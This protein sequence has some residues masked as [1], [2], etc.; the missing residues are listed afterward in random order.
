MRKFFVTFAIPAA[1]I[2]EWMAKVDEA[3]RKEQSDKVMHE[4]QDWMGKHASS[5]LDKGMPIGKTKR[6]MAGS[7]ADARNDLN[8]YLVVQAESHEA[9]AEMFKDHPHLQIPTSH[10]DISDASRP[11]M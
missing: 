6:V 3:T 4:W 8:W 9:A 7:I 11:G 10:I 2:Q 5:I 1:A